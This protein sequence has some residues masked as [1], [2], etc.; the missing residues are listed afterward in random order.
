[1]TFE[2]VFKTVKVSK[3]RIGSIVGKNGKVKTE[4]ESKCN[5]YIDV[6]GETGD[7]SIRLRN[8][9]SLTQSG[10]FKASEIILAIS[11]GFS[12]QRAFRLLS[13]ECI[14]QLVDLREYSGKSLNSLD[15]IKSRLIGQNGKFR[16]NL[17]DFSGS[18]ISI[19]GHFAGFIGTFDETSLALNAIL[20]ICKGS[21]HKSVYHML[22]EYKRK[23]KLER[24]ELWEKSK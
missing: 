23:K 3:D 19:Y 16:K 18:D 15:R 13:D 1:M 4:I 10:I 11:K 12:P 5:V 2:G 7:V 8:K 24:L 21:S 6:N 17:E 20:M 22:E 9:D 14:L